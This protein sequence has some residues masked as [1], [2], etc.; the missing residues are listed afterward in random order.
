MKRRQLFYQKHP[1]LA[2]KMT[3]EERGEDTERIIYNPR[4]LISLSLERVR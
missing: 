1:E 4:D 3:P 2:V